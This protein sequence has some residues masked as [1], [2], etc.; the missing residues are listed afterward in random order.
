MYVSP[1]QQSSPHLELDDYYRSANSKLLLVL[2]NARDMAGGGGGGGGYLSVTSLGGAHFLKNLHNLL[3]KKVCI[4]ILCFE[5]KSSESSREDIVYC[6][7]TNSHNWM[8]MADLK[9]L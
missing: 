1:V 2:Q 7:E 8:I 5:I 4:S 9:T 6:S 3:R